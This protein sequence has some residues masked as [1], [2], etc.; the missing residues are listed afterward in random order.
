MLYSNITQNSL[1]GSDTV[2]S[3]LCT[4]LKTWTMGSYSFHS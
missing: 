2:V 3:K 1:Y 4:F